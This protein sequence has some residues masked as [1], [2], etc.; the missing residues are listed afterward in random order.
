MMDI[1]YAVALSTRHVRMHVFLLSCTKP[2]LP[3]KF[4][5]RWGHRHAELCGIAFKFYICNH[6]QGYAVVV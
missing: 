6:S 3:C 2:S 4:K 1:F 5:R